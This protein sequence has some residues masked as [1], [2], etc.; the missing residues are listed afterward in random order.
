MRKLTAIRRKRS[1]AGRR[2]APV[3]RL[4]T[5]ADQSLAGAYSDQAA[6]EMAAEEGRA[7]FYTEVWGDNRAPRTVNVI[8]AGAEET[9]YLIR[10]SLHG[11]L[12]AIEGRLEKMLAAVGLKRAATMSSIDN[13]EQAVEAKG[14]V[15]ERI[16]SEDLPLPLHTKR[17]IVLEI[18]GLALLGVGD[19][20]FVSSAFQI[21]GLSDQRALPFLPFSQLQV[22]S[23]SVIVATLLLTRLGGHV[24]R[25]LAHLIENWRVHRQS[26]QQATRVLVRTAATA[27]VLAAS[28]VGLVL[29]LCGL[30]SVRESFFVMSGERVS[31]SLF[32]LIQG[33]VTLAGVVLSYVMAHPFDQ[34]WRSVTHRVQSAV[35]RL[36][37]DYGALAGLVGSYNATLRE[38]IGVIL[39]HEDWSVATVND[40]RRQFELVARRTQLAQP[41]P[42]EGLLFGELAPPATPLLVAEVGAQLEGWSSTLKVYPE[43]DMAEVDKRLAGVAES[44]A[45]VQ[46][47]LFDILSKGGRK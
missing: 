6:E 12:Q 31:G 17:R 16:E 39:E 24:F 29:L 23:T 35:K 30:G 47:E 45:A 4:R 27:V 40:A 25:T 19:L 2:E 9:E 8:R 43:L 41:E 14:K 34:E 18:L 36:G 22:A 13:L 15:T 32:Y 21:F 20:Y 46:G 44:D 7:G 10:H 37:A 26:G 28:I 33:G 3:T 38:R 42:V 5:T 1:K 11:V